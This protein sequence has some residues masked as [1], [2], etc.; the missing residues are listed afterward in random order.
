[1]EE[2]EVTL[3]AFQKMDKFEDG[4]DEDGLGSNKEKVEEVSKEGK[5]EEISHVAL[6]YC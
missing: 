1:M 5:G 4:S 3:M 6:K 2:I